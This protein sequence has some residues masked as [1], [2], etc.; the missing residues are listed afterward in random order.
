MFEGGPTWPADLSETKKKQSRVYN[1]KI[2]PA[3]NIDVDRNIYMTKCTYGIYNKLIV[4]IT[5]APRATNPSNT[6]T[7]TGKP[8][9]AGLP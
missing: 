8:N 3:P 7:Q 6:A 1:A 5:E 4:L 2:F 9:R